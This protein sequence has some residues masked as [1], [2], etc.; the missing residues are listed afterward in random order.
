MDLMITEAS[1]ARADRVGKKGEKKTDFTCD[2]Y[3]TEEMKDWWDE[4]FDESEDEEYVDEKTKDKNIVDK[5]EKTEEEQE[6]EA[7]WVEIDLL[8]Q[9]GV[10]KPAPRS[11]VMDHK[12]LSKKW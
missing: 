4:E 6:M 9:L 7:K 11:E 8:K 1:A 10:C 3:E 5:Q 2:D 12:M